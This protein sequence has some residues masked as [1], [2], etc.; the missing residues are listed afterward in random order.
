[1]RLPLAFVMTLVVGAHPTTFGNTARDERLALPT[2]EAREDALKQLRA[3]FATEYADTSA[4]GRAA[5]AA[6]LLDMESALTDDPVGRYVLLDQARTLSIQA[7]HAQ[8]ALDAV[9]RLATKYVVDGRTERFETVTQLLAKPDADPTAVANAAFASADECLQLGDETGANKITRALAERLKSSPDE[10]LQSRLRAL[11]AT[12]NLRLKVRAWRTQLETKPDDPTTNFELGAH[13]CFVLG[14]WTRGLPRLVKGS[15]PKLA[16]IARIELDDPR[17]A[18]AQFELA[19]AWFKYA[20]SAREDLRAGS[21]LRAALRFK[22]AE[23]GLTGL[24]RQLAAERLKK[25]EA[26][27]ASAPAAAGTDT[28]SAPSDSAST[29]PSDDTPSSTAPTT[30]IAIPAK[31]ANRSRA[32]KLPTV[33]AALTWLQKH[34]SPSGSWSATKFMSNCVDDGCVGEG[35]S[36]HDIGI[37]ALAVLAFLG[38]GH[39]PTSGPYAR[40]V[41]A[42]LRFLLARQD[43]KSGC[44]GTIGKP[45]DF[46][47]DHAIATLALVEA[48]GLTGAAEYEK[49]ANAGVRFVLAARN[50]NSAWRYDVPPTGENDVSVTG[51]M[52]LTLCAARDVGITVDD[53]AIVDAMR[54]IE[55][56]T[57]ATTWRTGYITKG[58]YSAREAGMAELWRPEYTEAMTAVAMLCRIVTGTE[59]MRSPALKGG[60]GL[61]HAQSPNWERA[62]FYYWYYGS[63]AMFQMSAADWQRWESKLNT[64][65][66]THQQT[67]GCAAGSWDPR[68]DPWGHR[69]GRVYATAILCLCAEAPYRYAR[70]FK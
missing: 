27:S 17:S 66:R 50:P 19:E 38:A 20:E 70:V 69:G 64:A 35:V 42:G 59:P 16:A 44:V 49:A 63:Q 54:Y 6:T 29:A 28:D 58:G 68:V 56:M 31:Y 34:Q 32:A 37:T 10:S 67:T 22:S 39:T 18:D 25:L 33:A 9:E 48:Y 11:R 53:S 14:D 30:R 12:V 26:T 5:L 40:A 1:M 61:L 65:L 60:A 3:H 2:V 51:W 21:Q 43:A 57:D 24:R 13:E 47:Y 41:E 62:D 55:S 7:S 45:R 8:R 52:V 46:L 36:E 15:D 4:A 23:P